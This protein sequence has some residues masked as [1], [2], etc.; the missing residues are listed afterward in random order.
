MEVISEK[1]TIDGWIV[2][3]GYKGLFKKILC[4]SR[5]HFLEIQSLIKEN[6]I[7]VYN[8]RKQK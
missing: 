3:V 1:Q 6:M 2:S 4:D 7:A 5:E 8:K